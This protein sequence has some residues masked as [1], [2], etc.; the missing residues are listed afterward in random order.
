[1]PSSH[2]LAM[3]RAQEN[4]MSTEANAN[5]QTAP[6]T[7]WTINCCTEASRLQTK[8]VPGTFQVSNHGLVTQQKT[9]R[10]TDISDV[11]LKNDGR[12]AVEGFSKDVMLWGDRGENFLKSERASARSDVTSWES[13]LKFEKA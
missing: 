12:C 1:M 9:T 7:T 10:T 8:R 6:T 5:E 13:F 4:P 11:V 2:K 3:N